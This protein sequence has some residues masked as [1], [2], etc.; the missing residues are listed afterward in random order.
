ANT[1]G[2]IPPEKASQLAAQEKIKI[3]TIGIGADE[4]LKRS[5]FITQKVNPSADLDEQMLTHIAETTGGQYFRARDTEALQAIYQDINELEPIAQEG[6]TYRPSKAI[7]F[8][9]LLS[10]LCLYLITLGHTAMRRYG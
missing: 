8:W 3:Y 2:E 10:A 5:L 9:F 1:A 4:M 6:K 7:Y